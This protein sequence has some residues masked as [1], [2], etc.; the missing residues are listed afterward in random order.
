MSHASTTKAHSQFLSSMSDTAQWFSSRIRPVEK[1]AEEI[2]RQNQ[3]VNSVRAVSF[4]LMLQ[5]SVRTTRQKQEEK[6]H[7]EA[8]AARQKRLQELNELETRATAAVR[9]YLVAS[10]K[11][12]IRTEKAYRVAK[13]AERLK[14]LRAMRHIQPE[15]KINRTVR[16]VC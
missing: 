5:C 15:S 8:D 10:T 11:A 1:T 6:Q 16:S 3:V 12:R 7:R 13:N 4:F 2:K 14:P 9:R